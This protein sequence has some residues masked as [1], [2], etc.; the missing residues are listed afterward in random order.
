MLT[1]KDIAH[2]LNTSEQ[3]IRNLIRSN[4]L[5]GTRVG[6]QWIVKPNHLK[7]FVK[8]NNLHPAQIDHLSSQSR[9]PEIKALSFFSGAMGLDLGLEKAG[10][11][12]ILAC[13]FDKACRKT[14]EANRPELALLGD[15][16]Q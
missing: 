11:N 4:I 5:T 15:I 8:K 10:I 6:R 3:H 9:N 14:I 16:W 7:E 13:E 1:V 12:I 2:E